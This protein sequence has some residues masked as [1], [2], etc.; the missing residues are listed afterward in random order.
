MWSSGFICD[1]VRTIEYWNADEKRICVGYIFDMRIY[2]MIEIKLEIRDRDNEREREKT[3]P[4][5]L[6]FH[7]YWMDLEFLLLQQRAHCTHTLSHSASSL[8][9]GTTLHKNWLFSLDPISF[10]NFMYEIVEKANRKN[11]P[12]WTKPNQT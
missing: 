11:H 5:F 7:Y 8:Y 3:L 1:L 12:N 6:I 9:D 10:R 2:A 4:Y